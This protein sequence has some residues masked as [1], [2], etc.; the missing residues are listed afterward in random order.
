MAT[1]YVTNQ[2]CLKCAR[3]PP[4]AHHI[5]FAQPRAMGIKVSDELI[6]PLCELHHQEFHRAHNELVLLN[7]LKIDAIEVARMLWQRSHKSETSAEPA[8]A[9]AIDDREIGNSTTQQ[10]GP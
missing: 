3:W 6:V 2:L 10:S 4:D 7:D 1:K 9:D 8:G 5:T